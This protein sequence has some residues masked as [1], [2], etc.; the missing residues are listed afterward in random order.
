MP[1]P[2]T[3]G[4]G[5]LGARPASG[6]GSLTEPEAPSPAAAR[7]DAFSAPSPPEANCSASGGVSAG[8]S[9]GV[10]AGASGGASGGV[11]A[12]ASGG[13]SADASGGSSAGDRDADTDGDLCDSGDRGEL[14]GRLG[15]P[16]QLRRLRWLPGDTP[17][18][19]RALSRMEIESLQDRKRLTHLKELERTLRSGIPPEASRRLSIRHHPELTA[20]RFAEYLKMPVR[21]GRRKSENIGPRRN[22]SIEPRENGKVQSDSHLPFPRQL[23]SVG[24]AFAYELSKCFFPTA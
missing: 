20:E 24:L 22:E 7:R 10:S 3:P 1:E 13:V 12:G 15:A 16:T 23:A 19:Q 2:V 21:S 5:G 8:A 14:S 18:I 11:S 9:G 6:A 4:G 17:P